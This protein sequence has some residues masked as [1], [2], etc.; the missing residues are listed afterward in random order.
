MVL[1]RVFVCCRVSICVCVCVRFRVLPIYSLNADGFLITCQQSFLA[2]AFCQLRYSKCSLS[3]LL[4][5]S[6]A[7]S[8]AP[9]RPLH[10]LFLLLLLPPLSLHLHHPSSPPFGVPFHAALSVLVT[11]CLF[12][13]PSPSRRCSPPRRHKPSLHLALTCPSLFS[14]DVLCS[15]I[16]FVAVFYFIF[17]LLSLPFCLLVFF[18]SFT[19]PFLFLFVVF[20][21]SSICPCFLNIITCSHH[22]FL[23]SFFPCFLFFPLFH[24]FSP[25]VYLLI[26]SFPPSVF[27]LFLP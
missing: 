18:P 9:S 2:E 14:S 5:L 3:S 12:Y 25:S 21:H 17:S 16:P 24:S 27:P 11:L 1:G 8:P 6:A 10:L 19:H 4:S 23:P 26:P 20:L 13:H 22:S 7:L 15:S